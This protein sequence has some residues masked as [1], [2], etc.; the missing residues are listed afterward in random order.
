MTARFRPP[1][2]VLP[3]A[4]LALIA[5]LATLQYR[6]LG[7]ISEAERDR[8]RATL[9]TG[10]SEFAQDFDREIARAF[11]LFQIE[12]SQDDAD[13]ASRF[14]ARYDRWHAT[15]RFPKLLKD[16]Y[17]YAPSAS[18]GALRRFD[19]GARSFVAAQWP[20]T[21]A[22]WRARLSDVEGI[23]RAGKLYRRDAL[24]QRLEALRAAQ[25]LA[26]DARAEELSVPEPHLPKGDVLLAGH[27]ESFAL[28]E[29]LSGE[30]WAVV[31]DELGRL[32][33]CGRSRRPPRAR[34]A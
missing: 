8:M 7:Q 10:A 3:I 32:F 6:W 19:P 30:R 17:F 13:F 22:D 26:R 33:F 2:F 4:L 14:A 27:C 24:D 20:A 11:L 28:G 12:P 25:K 21:M 23:V 16:C 18:S 31:R 5:L 29:R 9:R 15:S 34:T 1:L